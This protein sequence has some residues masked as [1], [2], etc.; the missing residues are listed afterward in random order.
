MIKILMNDN[1]V[2]INATEIKFIRLESSHREESNKKKFIKIQ[3]VDHELFMDKA[4]K[5]LLIWHIKFSEFAYFR[6]IFEFFLSYIPL[7]L[8]DPL[9]GFLSIIY[10]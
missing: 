10:H 8:K 2:N 6:G 1:S 4:K 5:S 9:I 7:F 3:S